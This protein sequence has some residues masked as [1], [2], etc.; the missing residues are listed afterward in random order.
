MCHIH[1]IRNSNIAQCLPYEGQPF[2]SI[3]V[4]SIHKQRPVSSC[5]FHLWEYLKP[6][7]TFHVSVLSICHA[8]AVPWLTISH[9]FCISASH[10]IIYYSTDVISWLQ[11]LWWLLKDST[12]H[13]PT[14]GSLHGP[15]FLKFILVPPTSPWHLCFSQI[16]LLFILW[17]VFFSHTSKDFV[18]FPSLKCSP[19]LTTCWTR[20]F[21]VLVA[22]SWPEL[23]TPFLMLL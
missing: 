20:T 4:Q 10:F 8:L 17:A 21:P 16:E 14:L 15:L 7:L 2:M 13:M 19:S 5:G 11:S 12:S 3:F 9:F 18:R 23:L 22:L 6:G 1:I